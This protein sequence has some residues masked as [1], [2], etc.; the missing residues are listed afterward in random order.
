MPMLQRGVQ[1]GKIE[2]S[3]LAMTPQGDLFERVAIDSEGILT[4]LLDLFPPD[5]AAPP[6]PPERWAVDV[7]RAADLLLLRFSFINLIPVDDPE[8]PVLL[9]EN[10]DDDA[11]VV[12]RF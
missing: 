2:E 12:V 3:G 6:T 11:F 1:L 7:T 4:H 5:P 8:G 9:R 10:E